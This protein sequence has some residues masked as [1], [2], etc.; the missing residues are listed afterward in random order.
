M[1]N[2]KISGYF[3]IF[4]LKIIKCFLNYDKLLNRIEFCIHA[5]LSQFFVVYDKFS[6]KCNKWLL[7][8]SKWYE[9]QTYSQIHYHCNDRNHP[10][11]L[12]SEHK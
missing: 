5:L 7:S 1:L 3:M 10:L 9:Q 4:V 2:I 6:L 8:E 11:K 12:N